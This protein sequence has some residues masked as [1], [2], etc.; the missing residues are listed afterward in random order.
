MITQ[1]VLSPG[2]NNGDTLTGAAVCPGSVLA[3]GYQIEVDRVGD[4]DKLIPFLN[5]PTDRQTWTVGIAASAN[6]Q[7]V[8]LTVSA[9]CGG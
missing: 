6:V 9:V 4:L 7:A 1:A 5:T 2:L 3:G 8:R